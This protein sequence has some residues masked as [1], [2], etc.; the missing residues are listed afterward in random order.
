MD[1]ILDSFPPDILAALSE[2]QQQALRLHLLQQQLT[3]SPEK[4]LATVLEAIDQD[5]AEE[6][7][8]FAKLKESPNTLVVAAIAYACQLL[9]GVDEEDIEA[10]VSSNPR[11]PLVKLGLELSDSAQLLKLIVKLT[12]TAQFKA[13]R[14]KRGVVEAPVSETTEPP[15]TIAEPRFPGELVTSKTTDKKS[16]EKAKSRV[17]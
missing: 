17:D 3:G 5:L 14:K 13:T 4:V 2:E 7:L 12:E 8:S 11:Y 6:D 15:A 10:Q 16:R 9:L 1:D